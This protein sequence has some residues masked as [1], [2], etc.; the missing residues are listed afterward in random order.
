MDSTDD[1]DEARRDGG[2]SGAD[3]AADLHPDGGGGDGRGAPVDP[4]APGAGAALGWSA[5]ALKRWRDALAERARSTDL[6]A[7]LTDDRALARIF[8]EDAPGPCRRAAS[9][10][11]GRIKAKVLPRMADADVAQLAMSAHDPHLAVRARLELERRGAG[12]VDQVAM[13][14]HAAAARAEQRA[15]EDSLAARI[16]KRGQRRLVGMRVHDAPIQG[17]TAEALGVTAYEAPLDAADAE[18]GGTV[19]GMRAP[20]AAPLVRLFEA[21]EITPGGLRGATRYASDADYVLGGQSVRTSALTDAGGGAAIDPMKEEERRKQDRRVRDRYDDAVGAL[22]RRQ[23]EMLDRCVRGGMSSPDA[24][25]RLFPNVR[26]ER[27]R[28]GLGDALL[29]EACDALAELWSLNDRKGQ[30]A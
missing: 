19:R 25:A 2:P 5:E 10:R 26:S 3:R 13:R 8:G 6:A 24:A 1:H 23:R 21:G 11:L 18:R 4:E 30:A 28:R 22:S 7:A 17:R 12:T 29:I 14:C 27:K 15:E 16:E 9:R 20:N